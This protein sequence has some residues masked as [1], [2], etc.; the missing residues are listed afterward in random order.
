MG[1][2]AKIVAFFIGFGKTP[3]IAEVMKNL[4]KRVDRKIEQDAHISE[5]M[6]KQLET[7]V[8]MASLKVQMAKLDQGRWLTAWI[9]PGF[10]APLCLWWAAVILDSMFHFSWTIDAL[11]GNMQ[12]WAGAII[13]SFFIVRPFEK[14]QSATKFIFGKLFGRKG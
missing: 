3:F 4:N 8:K 2:L 10:A 7:D 11:P 13:L 5:Y 6:L 1:F 12:N 9:R 14:A